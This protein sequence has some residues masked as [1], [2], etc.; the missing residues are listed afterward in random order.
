MDQ[1]PAR[2]QVEYFASQV[3][4]AARARG[5]E[6]QFA[7]LL[8]CQRDQLGQ[9]LRRQGRVDGED[10]R[11]L[12]DQGDRLEILDGVVVQ[13]RVQAGRDGQRRY[14][15][16]QQ[17]VSVGLR[18]SHRGGAYRAARAGLVLDDD[19]L[20]QRV[21]QL[22]RQRA[23]QRVGRAAGREGHHDADGLVRIR[24]GV[25]RSAQTHGQQPRQGRGQDAPA[26]DFPVLRHTAL[27]KEKTWSMR[28][29][30]QRVVA[31]AGGWLACQWRAISTRR[32]TQTSGCA[33]T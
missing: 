27:L 31:C 15:A 17:G 3:G 16:K 18:A 13:V 10:Q 5:P 12:A 28:K 30:N 23:R 19:L 29:T 9:V 2:R 26:I 32:Q 1:I 25:R 8:G 14:V 21:V 11:A 33:A 20:A 7:R 6:C 22:L 4:D 24:L